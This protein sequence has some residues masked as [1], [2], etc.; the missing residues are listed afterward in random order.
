MV[1]FHVN[2]NRDKYDKYMRINWSSTVL[3]PTP[4]IIEDIKMRLTWL[5]LEVELCREELEEQI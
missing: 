1:N 4:K 2:I 5:A 3:P